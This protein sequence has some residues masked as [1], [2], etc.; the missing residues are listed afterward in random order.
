LGEHRTRNVRHPT[1]SGPRG[2]NHEKLTYRF[3]GHD[4][5]LTDV[6]GEVVEK[7]IA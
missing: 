7:M 6:S 2:F 3:Q 1:S 4:F 5:R